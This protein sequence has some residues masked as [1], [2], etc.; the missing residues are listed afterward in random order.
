MAEYQQQQQHGPGGHYSGRNK[1][2]NI[3][4]FVDSLDRDKKERDRQI[5]DK[6]KAQAEASSA[7]K[8]EGDG[9]AR[10]HVERKT[11]G[12]KTRKE[13][14]DPTTGRHATIENVGKE[15]MSR[16]T[17]PVVQLHSQHLSDP[18]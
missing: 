5:D 15:T 2:P 4:E 14:T 10:P 18:C 1:I 16:V 17:D 3:K 13:V 6:E 12:E 8:T 7:P 9:D 11:G